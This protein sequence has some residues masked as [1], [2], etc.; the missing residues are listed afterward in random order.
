MDE[1]GEL[2]HVVNGEDFDEM[3][4]CKGDTDF[5][6][7]KAHVLERNKYKDILTGRNFFEMEEKARR[8]MPRM[9]HIIELQMVNEVWQR[10]LDKRFSRDDERTAK[11][12]VDEVRMD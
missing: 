11:R 10:V 6:R 8:M 2:F 3:M 1:V 12:K 5:D 4:G 9:N 7:R